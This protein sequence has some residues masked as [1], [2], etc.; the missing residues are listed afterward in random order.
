MSAG[1]QVMNRAGVMSMALVALALMLVVPGRALAQDPPPG[2]RQGG[3]QEEPRGGRDGRGGGRGNFDPEQFR[4]RIAER[5]KEALGA[6]DD[7]FA[8]I[9][10]KIEKVMNLQRQSAGGGMGMIFGGGRGGPGGGGPGGGGRGGRG[11]GGDDSPVSAARRDLQ[12]SVEANAGPDEL[13]A[14]MAALRDARAKSREELTKAQQELREL[15]TM[16]QEAALVMMG[17][18][19]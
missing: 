16:K 3:G 10:P 13:K 8:V 4:R 6:N 5:M 2:E 14:R 19:E 15:L 11:P 7:E 17:M 18:L 9:Q 1:M 12:K